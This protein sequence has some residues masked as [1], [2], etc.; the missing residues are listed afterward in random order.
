MKNGPTHYFTVNF[1]IAPGKDGPAVK[2]VSV[3]YQGMEAADE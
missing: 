3:E 2:I 1:R